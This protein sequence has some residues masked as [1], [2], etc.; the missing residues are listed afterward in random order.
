MSASQLVDVN[1]GTGLKNSFISGVGSLLLACGN[2]VPDLQALAE[3][4]LINEQNQTNPTEEEPADNSSATQAYGTDKATAEGITEDNIVEKLQEGDLELK[5]K[6]SYIPDDN[7]LALEALAHEYFKN[8]NITLPKNKELAK[9]W[10]ENAAKVFNV[11][12]DLFGVVNIE[13]TLE[14]EPTDGTDAYT[15]LNNIRYYKF[16]E[17]GIHGRTIQV[18]NFNRK[19]T[20]VHELGHVIDFLLFKGKSKEIIDTSFSRLN[21][22]QPDSSIIENIKAI[23]PYAYSQRMMDLVYLETFAEALTDVVINGENANILSQEII[24]SLVNMVPDKEFYNDVKSWMSPALST[25]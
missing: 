17:E 7:Y 10:I 13:L 3:K 16:L 20:I 11:F 18:K 5:E 1:G 9:A 21:G 24:K 25:Y 15:E 12:P 19:F 6:L 4:P 2:F 8:E 23:S 14:E 22:G